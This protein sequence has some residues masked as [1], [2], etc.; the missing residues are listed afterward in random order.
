MSHSNS[1]KPQGPGV[2]LSRLPAHIRQAFDKTV[3]HRPGEVAARILTYRRM[4]NMPSGRL[5]MERVVDVAEKTETVA[6]KL[7][8]YKGVDTLA[9]I[10]LQIDTL[11]VLIARL[12]D[13]HET[14]GGDRNLL[15]ESLTRK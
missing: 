10:E 8:D 15:L 9:M 11:P 6:M 3:G 14:S 1:F 4:V 5:Y 7:L 13:L 12:V 2:D